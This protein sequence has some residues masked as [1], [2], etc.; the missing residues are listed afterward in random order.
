MYPTWSY[1]THTV[2]YAANLGWSN[3]DR[4]VIMSQL[5]WD[6]NKLLMVQK[7]QTTNLGCKKKPINNGRNYQA[8]W[9]NGIISRYR[10]LNWWVSF[11][12][13]FP[14]TVWAPP[15]P[16]K[17]STSFDWMKDFSPL[18][19]WKSGVFQSG[20]THRIFVANDFIPGSPFNTD[21]QPCHDD[22]FQE[23]VN[24]CKYT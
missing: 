9:T 8:L 20:K 15:S 12:D 3:W 23:Q 2:I 4:F 22:N 10:S 6:L 24:T 5:N 11:P 1:H 13:L 21:S 14:S 17:L 16:W 18:E 19:M 7:S